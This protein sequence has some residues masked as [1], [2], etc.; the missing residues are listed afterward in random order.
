[1]DFLFF[2]IFRI[3]LRAFYVLVTSVWF[4]LIAIA[5]SA[6]LTWLTVRTSGMAKN[7]DSDNSHGIKILRVSRRYS[8]ASLLLI[9]VFPVA[10]ILLPALLSWLGRLGGKSPA[11]PFQI[12]AGL[13]LFTSIPFLVVGGSIITASIGMALGIIGK[14]RLED[15][16]KQNARLHIQCTATFVVV[17]IFMTVL[18]LLSIV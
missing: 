11:I 1:M 5:I 16:N 8:V 4:W 3:W 13:S 10:L 9:T 18:L 12:T 17:W 2:Y 6:F 14:R 15:C 7:F